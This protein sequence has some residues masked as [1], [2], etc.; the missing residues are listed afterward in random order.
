MRT[1]RRTRRRTRV[2]PRHLVARIIATRER[3]EMLT[4]RQRLLDEIDNEERRGGSFTV[5]SS[6]TISSDADLR[7]E[8]KSYGCRMSLHNSETVLVEWGGPR[9]WLTRRW[10]RD[11]Y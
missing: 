10:T 11:N 3:G 8:L 9:D 6:E 7:A 4:A 1:A 5:C 2:I